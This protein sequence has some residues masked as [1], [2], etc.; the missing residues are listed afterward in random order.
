VTAVSG[1][2][3]SRDAKSASDLEPHASEVIDVAPNDRL[4]GPFEVAQ[5]LL[6]AV[7]LTHPDDAIFTHQLHHRPQRVTRV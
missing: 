2:H 5:R 3:G 1:G 4:A 7:C 6:S